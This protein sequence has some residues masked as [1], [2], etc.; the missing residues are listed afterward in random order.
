MNEN[1]NNNENSLSETNERLSLFL[2]NDMGIVRIG[3]TAPMFTADS[4][5]GKVSL[6]DYS[7]KWLIFFCH[8]GDFTPV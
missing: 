4:T 1:E 6:S 8:P 3:S 2:N 5:F 7:S